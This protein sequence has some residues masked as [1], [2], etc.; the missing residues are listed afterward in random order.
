[1]DALAQHF[2]AIASRR[3]V[4]TPAEERTWLRALEAER[5][6]QS[7]KVRTRHAPAP[8]TRV[9]TREVQPNP[10]KQAAR[11]K[12]MFN[13]GRYAAGARDKAAQDADKALQKLLATE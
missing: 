5:F 12:V 6:D 7:W 4:M 3:A 13:A 1:M 10:K 11:D 8:V 2:D 9:I